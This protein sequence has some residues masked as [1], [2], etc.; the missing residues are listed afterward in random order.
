MLKNLVR[1]SAVVVCLFAFSAQADTKITT[2]TNQWSATN[3]C[4]VSSVYGSGNVIVYGVKCPSE[5]GKIVYVE[6]YSNSTGWSYSCTAKTNT[7]GYRTSTNCNNYSVYRVAPV[8]VVEPP[9]PVCTTTKINIGQTCNGANSCMESFGR[10][11]AAAGGSAV[12][13]NGSYSCQKTTCTNP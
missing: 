5:N 4:T 9:K 6:Q 8:V 10:A 13:A 7:S 3:S 11:C 12:W 2:V 1:L